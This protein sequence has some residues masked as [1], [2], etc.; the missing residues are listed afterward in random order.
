MKDKLNSQM[1]FWKYYQ[2]V[3][4]KNVIPYQWKA[5]NDE[6]PDTVPSHAIDNFKMAAGELEGEYYGKVFQDSDLYK[7]LESVA[8]IL[9]TN[10]DEE[11]EK[12]ADEMID[13]IGRAQQPDGYINTY[14]QLAEGLD[15]RWTNLAF[16]HELY[17]AG[18]LIEAAVAYYQ[19]T[20]KQKFLDIAIRLADCIDRT[21]GTEEGK[22]HGYPG[23]EEIELAL[24]RLYLTTDEKRYLDL[25]GYFIN[26][27][28]QEPNYLMKENEA[29]ADREG[30][31]IGK[32][33][34]LDYFQAHKPIREQKEVTG[35]AVRAMY[36]YTGVTD[37]ARL[38]GDESLKETVRNLW[39]NMV[40]E[41]L[42]VNGGIGAI[43]H[44]EAFGGG[45]DLPNDTMYNETCASVGL[46]FWANRMLKMEPKGEYADVMENAL[47]NGALG[48]MDLK[49]QSFLYVNPL[50]IDGPS[51]RKRPDHK[52]VAPMRQR[53]FNCACCPPNL[54]RLI[55]SVDDY[56]ITEYQNGLYVNLYGAGEIKTL[57]KQ[58]EITLKQET[59]YPWDGQIVV[60]FGSRQPVEGKIGFR[61]PGWSQDYLAKVNGMPVTEKPE[62][63]F[64]VI[65]RKWQDGDAVE[66]SFDM[67]IQRL[68]ANTKVTEDIGKV[69][70]R[71]GPLIYVAEET[72]NGTGLGQ[73]WL[74]N[75]EL[76]EWQSGEAL[77][78]DA[79]YI[80]GE[81]K[82]LSSSGN[83]LYSTEPPAFT[84]TEITLI[85][86]FMWGNR[87]YGEIR[88]WLNAYN[89]Q[90]EE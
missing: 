10:P 2:S 84:D 66:L 4:K 76:K 35:H 59:K 32:L 25:A 68:Y 29:G 79:V 69:A 27:R 42:Y 28:G 17:C 3:V 5:L 78:P 90:S 47:Y 16:N 34:G 52:H 43:S 57:W 12:T 7:W 70:I 51:A 8:Y 61:I 14:C 60:R 62:N 18:H 21:F 77:M 80:K 72:D 87:G 48:G 20:G 13:L 82:R 11:L 22:C 81:G 1:P 65:D 63:G 15:A 6:L 85:P 46:T 73:L 49:G 30:R 74:C 38:A 26:Q 23:H 88:V 54:A 36:F 50:Q 53:W 19:T 39:R 41:K 37:Y 86:Y 75:G 58:T 9:R 24:V 83:Q 33:V 67:S 31:R 89:L 55:G 71:R 64:L 44:G 45:Y 56:F 40:D